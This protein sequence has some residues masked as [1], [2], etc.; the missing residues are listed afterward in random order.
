MLVD[1]IQLILK[2]NQLFLS[3]WGNNSRQHDK[4]MLKW[5]SLKREN[6]KKTACLVQKLLAGAHLNIG[7]G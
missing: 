7:T 5:T 3:D 1:H 4:A 2:E 6:Q